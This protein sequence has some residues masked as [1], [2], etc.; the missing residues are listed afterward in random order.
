MSAEDGFYSSTNK[1]IGG[2]SVGPEKNPD[3]EAIMAVSRQCCW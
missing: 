2:Q 3:R 1:Q